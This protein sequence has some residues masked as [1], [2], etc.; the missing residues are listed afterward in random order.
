MDIPVTI[1]LTGGTGYIASHTAT[2]L[3]EAGEQVVLYD[4]LC[5]SRRDVVARLEQLAGKP[6][7]FVQGDVRDQ[8][9]VQKTLQDHGCDAVVHFAGLKAVGESV[10]EPVRYYANN[11][12]GTISLL[13]A[14]AG[15]GV[16]KVVFSSSATIYGE[17]Q[18][19]PYD[20]AHPT[21]AISP[22]GR[23]KLH[24]EQ[25]LRDLCTSDPAWCAVSLRY[26]N[27]VGAHDSGLIGEEPHGIP[28]NLM[29]F[30]AKVAA[31]ELPA[32]NIFGTDYPT[33]DGTGVRD[34]I[35]VMDLAEGHLAGI[36]FLRRKLGFHPFNLGTGHGYSVLEVIDAFERA[37]Q[38]AL[39]RRLAARRDGDLASFYANPAKAARD[40]G[41]RA[42]RSLDQMCQSTWNWQRSGAAK[43]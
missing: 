11:V 39:P 41:W 35:H 24:I 21:A 38:K 15:A 27:P 5:N 10:A 36:R 25:M 3:L 1:L 34:F 22:Y 40:L 13:Q 28:N 31:G 19:L 26:F 12:Q 23:S 37:C 29:P 20:E 9:Q 30:V 33:P 2:T 42:T 8:R 14:M 16:R 6:V 7:A 4:N 18:Y 17:P 43:Q 32:I